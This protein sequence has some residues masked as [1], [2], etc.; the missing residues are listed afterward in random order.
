MKVGIIYTAYN[1]QDY[2]Q[3][4]LDAFLTAREKKLANCEFF[5]SAVSLPFAEYKDQIKSPD[6]TSGLLGLY[7]VQ[8][9]IDSLIT[10][11]EYIPEAQAR[12]LAAQKCLDAG[13]DYLWI[14]DGDEFI[15]IEQIE[16]IIRFITLDKFVTWFRLSLKNYV[17]N[18]KTYIEEPFTPPRI[19][20]VQS[21]GFKFT[22]F[23]FDNDAIYN[24]TVVAF[25]KFLNK[26][27]SDKE[28]PSKTI[29]AQVAWIRHLTWMNDEKSKLKIEYQNKHFGG[30]CSYA[31]DEVQNSLI[32]NV[33]YYKKYNKPL[34][35]LI[36]EN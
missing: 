1:M 21:N 25:G 15:T 34:P 14:A 10:E 29:P 4:S 35:N 17:F 22:R 18:D 31:W 26:D 13:C 8:N 33:D 23:N 36:R 20:R 32:F 27:V 2:L 7:Y 28:L 30:I 24:G 9:Q 16:N 6:S 5:I 11:P 3:Q 12:T 19:W